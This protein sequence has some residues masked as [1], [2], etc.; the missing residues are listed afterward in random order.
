MKQSAT[1]RGVAP[2]PRAFALAQRAVVIDDHD[3]RARRAKAGTCNRILALKGQECA[4]AWR[5]WHTWATIISCF[6]VRSSLP[7]QQL[8]IQWIA[9]GSFEGWGQV[10]FAA[11]RVLIFDCGL[12]GGHVGVIDAF[13][14]PYRLGCVGRGPGVIRRSRATCG[15]HWDFPCA[16]LFETLVFLF[17]VGARN[18]FAPC[19]GQEHRATIDGRL[20]AAVFVH[21][22]I[23]F[24]VQRC[25]WICQRACMQSCPAARAR[26][27]G[28]RLGSLSFRLCFSHVCQAKLHSCGAMRGSQ[29]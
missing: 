8:F 28:M 9:S 19:K 25:T 6:V 20:C 15:S 1:P 29:P 26:V 4:A 14:L 2:R 24:S 21:D 13:R 17:W 16:L 27:A 22:R 3:T 18:S 12:G 7:L 5:C 23:A 11:T 10:C